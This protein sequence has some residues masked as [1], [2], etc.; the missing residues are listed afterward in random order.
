MWEPRED[1]KGVRALID[2]GVETLGF[3]IK[4]LL[5]SRCLAYLST[6]VLGFR[7]V[8]LGV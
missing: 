3:I 5:K 2:A 1:K 8:G 6:Y 4:H 7:V